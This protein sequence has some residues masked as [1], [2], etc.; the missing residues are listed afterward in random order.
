MKKTAPIRTK[1]EVYRF[2]NLLK[3]WNGN[4][5]MAASI[6]IH[7]GL[8]CSDILALRVGD[9]IAGE[10]K[11]VQIVDRLMVVE[12]KTGHERHILVT[13]DMKDVLYEHIK[14]HH[15]PL[16][17][18][19]PLVLSRNRGDEG[20]RKP[21]SRQRLWYVVTVAA[22][23]IGIKGPIGTH[24]LRK[25]W[26]YQ[27]WDAGIGVDVIQKELGH[28][29]VETTHRYASIPDERFDALYRKINF[30]LPAGVRRRKK[31]N[32]CQGRSEIFA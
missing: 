26:A 29:S 21:L 18:D 3:N 14:R 9:V 13:D 24:S 10:G 28:A 30:G 7:W 25:T 19:V 20:A 8:R 27:A 5:Y 11:R 22:S 32:V 17:L 4:Y 15:I 2:L 31:R 12:I 16:D 1:P 6:G 23:R